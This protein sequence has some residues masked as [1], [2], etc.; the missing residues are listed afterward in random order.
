MYVSFNDVFRNV[1]CRCR[2]VANTSIQRVPGG[3][4]QNLQQILIFCTFGGRLTLG[5]TRMAGS[6]TTLPVILSFGAI[7]LELLA[8]SLNEPKTK[9]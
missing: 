3:C 7:Q 8:S 6:A 5:G 2:S 4:F 1:L 9:A